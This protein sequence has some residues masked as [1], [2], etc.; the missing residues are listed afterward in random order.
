VEIAVTL[1]NKRNRCAVVCTDT[2]TAVMLKNADD[3]DDADERGR[4]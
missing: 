1:L 2:G 4:R 3:A